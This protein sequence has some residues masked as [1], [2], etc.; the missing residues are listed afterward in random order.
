MSVPRLHKGEF[1][2]QTFFQNLKNVLQ[3]FTPIL[4]VPFSGKYFHKKEIITE[5]KLVLVQ[6]QSQSPL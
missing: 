4:H 5:Y 1:I 6:L 3:K 2:Q